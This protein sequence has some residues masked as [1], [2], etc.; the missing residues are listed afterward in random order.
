[1]GRLSADDLRQYIVRH[2]IQV[3]M[4]V[5]SFYAIGTG[6]PCT[7]VSMACLGAHCHKTQDSLLPECY[8]RQLTVKST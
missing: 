3:C 6:R 4:N 5:C 7:Y 8:I 1:M 2:N